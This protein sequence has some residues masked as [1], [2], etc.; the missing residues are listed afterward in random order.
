MGLPQPL[1]LCSSKGDLAVL[2]AQLDNDQIAS[3]SGQRRRLGKCAA[4]TQ[5][6]VDQE[7]Q[8]LETE[9]TDGPDLGN[10]SPP[11]GCTRAGEK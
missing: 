3:G 9:T 8:G 11:R 7:A 2:M 1:T 4:E 5:W 6:I 10:C